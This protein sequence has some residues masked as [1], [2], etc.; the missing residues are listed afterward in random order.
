MAISGQGIASD[1][2]SACRILKPRMTYMNHPSILLP[3]S[4]LSRL[5]SLP[6]C[7]TKSHLDMRRKNV[8]CIQWENCAKPEAIMLK[9]SSN[10]H[11]RRTD[12]PSQAPS[13]PGGKLAYAVYTQGS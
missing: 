10:V 5:H 11:A 1:D 7:N 13:V 8:N 2:L 3:A 6:H 9:A 4:D 12:Q